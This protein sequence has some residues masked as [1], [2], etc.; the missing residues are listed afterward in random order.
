MPKKKEEIVQA[1]CASCHQVTNHSV[2]WEKPM[3]KE[4]DDG[5]MWESTTY[6]ALMCR[7]CEKI[8]FKTIYMFSEELVPDGT[9][10]Y[11]LVETIRFYPPANERM[12]KTIEG[13]RYAPPKVRRVYNETVEAYNNE[14]RTLCAI[15]IRSIIEA[16]CIEEGIIQHGLFDKIKELTSK[17]IVT[18]KLG[19]GLQE[20]RLLGN[21]SAH[22]LDAFGDLELVTAIKLIEN[23][24]E[25]HYAIEDRINSL[26]SRKPRTKN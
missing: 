5:E 6:Q 2:E 15:G 4:S 13:V 25:S 22:Q 21:D 23:V 10:D 7:G 17:K 14:L 1:F 24:I 3:R 12:I 18:P 11:E 20:S 16:I 26:K 19:A 9:G 8:V